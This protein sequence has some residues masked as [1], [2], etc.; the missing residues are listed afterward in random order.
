MRKLFVFILENQLSMNRS[1]GHLNVACSAFQDIGA[2]VETNGIFSRYSTTRAE[3]SMIDGLDWSRF[4]RWHPSFQCVRNEN[5]ILSLIILDDGA[6]R[7]WCRAQG[8][9]EHVHILGLNGRSEKTGKRL[10]KSSYRFVL[11]F[12]LAVTNLQ[13]SR[14]IIQT[15][16]T[17][18]QLSKFARARKPSFQIEFLRS[19]VVQR[20]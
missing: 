20:A 4:T 5:S 7:S 12:H 3:R 11:S 8:R 17:W 6:D 13:S 18:D 19:S 2:Q 14:L 16:G 1:R 9:I 15:V 10:R